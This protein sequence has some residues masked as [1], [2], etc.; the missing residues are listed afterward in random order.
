MTKPEQKTIEHIDPATTSLPSMNVDHSS[1]FVNELAARLMGFDSGIAA[2][3]ADMDG[4]AAKF[5]REQSEAR[6]RHEADME[7]RRRLKRDLERARRMSLAAQAAYEEPIP[8]D[9]TEN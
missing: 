5:E 2:V 4:M 7:D 8:D 1:V 9:V 6:I 3:V